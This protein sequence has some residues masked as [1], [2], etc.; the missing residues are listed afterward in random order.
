MM[1]DVLVVGAGPAGSSLALRL[2][3]AGHDVAV[4]DRSRF[5]RGKACGDYLCAG[6]IRVLQELG[7]ERAVLAGARPIRGVALHGFGE[8]VRFAL[9][10]EGAR[11]LPRDVLDARLV[12]EAVAAG[13]QL[14]HGSFLHTEPERRSLHVLFRDGTGRERSMQTKM[15]VG[16][17]GS[18]SVVALRCGLARGMQREGRWAMGGELHESDPGDELEMFI[19]DEGY[20]ARNPLSAD[21]VNSMLVLAQP[22]Q[23]D[24]ADA[25]VSAITG[26]VR[27]FEREK[28]AKVVAI[29]P[30]AYRAKTVMRDRVLLTG[31][32]AE[33][34]DPFTGQGVSTA[35][36]LSAPAANAVHNVL[37]G[38][39]AECVA[40]AYHAQWKAVVAPR[41]RL[42]SLVKTIV[43]VGWVRTRVL[44][45]LRRDP[46]LVQA[47]LAAVTDVIPPTS[48]LEP[49]RLW[50]LL[51]A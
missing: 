37:A 19:A 24:R 15:L 10:G 47:V 34:L 1:V 23:A 43:G 46:A 35:L 3:R 40:R 4:L 29:G 50:R 16:A 26:G 2:A 44:R 32:A 20:Y 18:R 8:H 25:V 49:N 41:R 6:G 5:P 42:G 9:P 22:A 51:V 28:I 30:L 12:A 7:I 36:S 17:D 21:S 11:S 27:R 39:P 48:V 31:D 33:F 45:N 14:L 38:H 13:A